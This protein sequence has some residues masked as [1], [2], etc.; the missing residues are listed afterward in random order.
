MVAATLLYFPIWRGECPS[1]TQFHT[2]AWCK[3][4]ATIQSTCA[5]PDQGTW[6]VIWVELRWPLS[7]HAPASATGTHSG[8]VLNLGREALGRSIQWLVFQ[9]ECMSSAHS[10][11]QLSTRSGV[12]R[13][14]K[15]STTE[16]AQILRS[17]MAT[18][19]PAVTIPPPQPHNHPNTKTR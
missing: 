11:P 12:D 18:S 1:S 8:R 3:N 10:T 7:M 9:Q 15:K 6:G 14:Q 2:T 5:E 16:A 4:K 13:S 17:G 19:F